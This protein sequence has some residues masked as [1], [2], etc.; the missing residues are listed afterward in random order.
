MLKGLPGM[1][2]LL[3]GAAVV[4]LGMLAG[5]V[6]C[7]LASGGEVY[8]LKKST[9]GGGG[10]WRLDLS[11]VPEIEELARFE[12]DDQI[13]VIG[14]DPTP[15]PPPSDRIAKLTDIAK[16]LK[17]DEARALAVLI[18]T[19]R[20]SG[21]ADGTRAISIA[22]RSLGGLLSTEEG[23]RLRAWHS[24]ALDEVQ[25]FNQQAMADVLT[26]LKNAHD[27]EPAADA[28]QVA[29]S[30]ASGET[31]VQEI[32]LDRWERILQFVL[33]VIQILTDLGIINIGG[34][35]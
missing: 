25:R 19:V 18:K 13:L 9:T 16:A 12:A 35:S 1:M 33:R 2:S 26:S 5:L 6:C 14:D 3:R 24:A 17:K 20:D 15:E 27:V 21:T 22:I 30:I 23:Q 10:L 28:V 4:L 11:G 8:I 34:A 32:D 7:G 29:Q 31:T